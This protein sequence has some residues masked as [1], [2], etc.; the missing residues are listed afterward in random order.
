MDTATL[1]GR[2]VNDRTV[3]GC[4]AAVIAVDSASGVR[5]VAAYSAVCNKRVAI[6]AVDS[7]A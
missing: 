4:R 5:P 7:A 2:I 3:G 6:S 1:V